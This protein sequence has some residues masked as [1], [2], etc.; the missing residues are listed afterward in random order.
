LLCNKA[1]PCSDNLL[2]I[3]LVPANIQAFRA[4]LKAID[5]DA[6]KL[7]AC[8]AMRDELLEQ[9]T[10]L[11]WL[12]ACAEGVMVDECPHYKEKRHAWSR[13][14][15][16]DADTQNEADVKQWERFISIAESGIKMKGECLAPLN[17]TSGYWGI[18]MV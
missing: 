6:D 10:G 7:K 1:N 5:D 14:L 15:D 12:F 18:D 13:K 2:D 11:G 3:H 17:K 4:S 8:V 9:Q 16:V